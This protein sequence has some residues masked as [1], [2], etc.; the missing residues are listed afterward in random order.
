MSLQQLHSGFVLLS[1]I[2]FVY[3]CFFVTFCFDFFYLCP[4]FFF[5]FIC[6]IAVSFFPFQS[7]RF[8]YRFGHSLVPA[9]LL[10]MAEGRSSRR[11]KQISLKEV[12]WGEQSTY[13]TVLV[14]FPL[15][16]FFRPEDMKSPGEVDGLVRGLTR[17]T[18]IR[19]GGLRHTFSGPS[20]LYSSLVIQNRIKKNF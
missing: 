12:F 2:F 14:I 4:L 8:V 9:T 16:V 18:L 11:P 15:Q 7:Y 6:P 1:F 20:V 13:L 10:S 17:Q 3:S 5:F 19:G